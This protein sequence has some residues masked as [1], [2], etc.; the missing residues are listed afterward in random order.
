M[1]R[2]GAISNK[3]DMSNDATFYF[4]SLKYEIVHLLGKNVDTYEHCRE[5]CTFFLAGYGKT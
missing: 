5:S 1:D 4:A 2:G 3:L